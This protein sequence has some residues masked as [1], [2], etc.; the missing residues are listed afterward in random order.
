MVRNHSKNLPFL[1]RFQ[2]LSRMVLDQ[3]RD[4]ELL[5]RRPNAVASA[6]RHQG[7][8]EITQFEKEIGFL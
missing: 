1:E 8:T 2:V 6:V 5:A 3:R 4:N 7:L